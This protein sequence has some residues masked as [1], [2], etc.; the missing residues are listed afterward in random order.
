MVAP[1]SRDRQQATTLI[2][3]V[4][5]PV[6]L[7]ILEILDGR[8]RS[9]SQM[10][11]ELGLTFHAVNHALRELL[12]L[13]LVR[14]V[15]SEPASATANTLRKIYTATTSGWADFADAAETHAAK[16]LPRR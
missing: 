3:S 10:A 12:K 7:R 2:T 9:A 4:Q 11:D 1:V 13:E 5:G 8:E 15:R 14:L 16:L 6:R